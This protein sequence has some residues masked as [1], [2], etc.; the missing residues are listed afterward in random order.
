MYLTSRGRFDQVKISR[1]RF[2]QDVIS[3]GADLT[4]ILFSV[5]RFDGG[6]FGKGPICL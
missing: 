6:Q 5:G 4:S 2:D 3:K 1:G